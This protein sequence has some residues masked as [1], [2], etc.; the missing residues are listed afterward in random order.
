[1]KN[2]KENQST[3]LNLH[4]FAP[5]QPRDP[6]PPEDASELTVSIKD[7]AG[8]AVQEGAPV[9][10][11][12]DGGALPP[13]QLLGAVSYCYA[14][15]VYTSEDIERKMLHDPKL[16]DAVGG[17]MPSARAIRR[18]RVLNHDAIRNTLERAFRFLRRKSAQETQ[19]PLPGQPATAAPSADPG[20]ST[21]TV[22]RKQAE[23]TLDR[24]A[25]IDNMSKD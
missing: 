13:E 11:P 23:Q 18:F 15:G 24:A 5:G 1:M 25:F 12:N 9:R 14:K 6:R 17:D 4:K 20:E 10:A 3:I 19:Q 8:K 22:A 7:A 21:V 2:E 16:R